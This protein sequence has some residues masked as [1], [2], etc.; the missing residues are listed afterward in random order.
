MLNKEGESG[1][2]CLNPLSSLNSSVGAPFTS[3]EAFIDEN[4]DL[5]QKIHLSQ[6]PIP[7]RA[8]NKKSQST[9][10]NVFSKSN[11]SINPF[12]LSDF[13]SAPLHW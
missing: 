8:S 13:I 5:S 11:F 6:N 3:I 12:I 9:E 10:S 4:N 2:P 7:D 1:S